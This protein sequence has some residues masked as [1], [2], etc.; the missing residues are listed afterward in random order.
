MEYDL[1]RM[2][3]QGD[4]LDTLP[5]LALSYDVTFSL[6][7]DLIYSTRASRIRFSARW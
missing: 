5:R 2:G 3:A 6:Y 7:V 4:L 1:F